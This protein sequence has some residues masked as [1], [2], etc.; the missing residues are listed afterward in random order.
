MVF[1][2]SLTSHA[3]CK[4]KINET[5]KF[6][7]TK[8]LY[9][10]KEKLFATM[11]KSAS[12]SFK[13]LD[14]FKYLVL[15]VALTGKPYYIKSG[16]SLYFIFS[17]GTKMELS[18][19]NSSDV[20]SINQGSSIWLI[21]HS[22]SLNSDQLFQLQNK[23]ITDIRFVTSNGYVESRVKTKFAQKVLNIAKCI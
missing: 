13:Q 9:T 17:G 8:K 14:S 18:N 23:L 11:A 12:I 3:Q 22:Y 5:D 19:N 1:V 15:S 16:V 6:T 21:S 4:Y 10:E 2:G 7:G 20:A